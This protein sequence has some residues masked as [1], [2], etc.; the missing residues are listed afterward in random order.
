MSFKA[1][2]LSSDVASMVS[3]V[4]EVVTISSSLFVTGTGDAN[5]KKF[6]N[7]AS[8]SVVLG[9]YWQ[10]VYDASP[11]ASTS[12]PLLDFTFGYHTSSGYNVAGSTS[13]SQNEKLKVYR[14]MASSLY[15]DP[16]QVF[17][18][19]GAS[20]PAAF[21]IMVKRGLQKDELKKGSVTVNM[22]NGD[23]LTDTGA[24][25]AFQQTI[26]GDYG[27]LFSGSTR[28]GQVWYNAGLIVLPVTGVFVDSVKWLS[29]TV[30]LSASL[31]GGRIDELVDGLRTKVDKLTFHNQTN[32]YSSIY[33]C[34]ATNT[35]FNYSS[36]PTFVDD[37]KRIRITSGSNILQTRTYITTIGLYDANDNL[38]AVAKVN[39]PITKSPD[40]EATFK[41]RLDY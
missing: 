22:K 27:Y 4:N 19:A 14:E 18:I 34:R 32:L 33:F 39:K 8:A 40:N 25:T 31:S 15:G 12:T 7:I 37:N 1:F 38:L 20:A 10:S 26:G 29:G 24:A 36:N 35:E 21:F 5:V 30:G 2:D 23:S 17:S 6:N 16:D 3:S 13:A 11:T 28:V 41:I 9:G